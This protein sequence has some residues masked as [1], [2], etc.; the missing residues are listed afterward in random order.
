MADGG[1]PNFESTPLIEAAAGLHEL[2]LAFQ[3]GGFTPQEAL[4]LVSTVMLNQV[5]TGTDE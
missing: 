2:Y 1:I 3:Q 5:G 4:H